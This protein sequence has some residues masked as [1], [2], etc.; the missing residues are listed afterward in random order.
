MSLDC[1]SCGRVDKVEKVSAVYRQSSA[2]GGISVITELGRAL[3]PPQP[4]QR[5]GVWGCF[6]IGLVILGLISVGEALL[7]FVGWMPDDQHVASEAFVIGVIIIGCVLLINTF[8]G[9]V[10]GA[11]HN[12]RVSRWRESQRKWEA[13]YYCSRCDGVFTQGSTFLIPTSSI[14]P[15]F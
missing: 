14:S 6:T 10:I 2:H 12:A 8:R 7:A 3:S 9:V 4:P 11:S 13:M 15:P 1:P 5:H